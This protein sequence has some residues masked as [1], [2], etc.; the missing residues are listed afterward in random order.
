MYRLGLGIRRWSSIL[1]IEQDGAIMG[2][3]K[4]RLSTLGSPESSNIREQDTSREDETSNPHCLIVSS[5][6]R[7]KFLLVAFFIFSMPLAIYLPNT[8]YTY[9][10]AIFALFMI[11]FLLILWTAETIL[12]QNKGYTPRLRITPLFLPLLALV[13]VAALSMVNSQSLTVSLSSLAQ[14]IYFVVFYQ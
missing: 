6:A 14:L 1:H 9:T 2:E 11:S 5:L 12:H 10:K 3:D 7:A 13:G 4:Q 8:S